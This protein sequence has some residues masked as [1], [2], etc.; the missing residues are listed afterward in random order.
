MVME[1]GRG[2]VAYVP[3]TGV[4]Y[5]AGTGVADAHSVEGKAYMMSNTRSGAEPEED[6]RQGSDPAGRQR[7]A[8]RPII[9]WMR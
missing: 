4:S 8:M 5:L 3:G 7:L 6:C 2:G 1:V 9:R